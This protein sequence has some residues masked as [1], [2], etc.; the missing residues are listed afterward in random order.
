MYGAGEFSRCIFKHYNLSALNIIGIAD[1]RFEQKRP[2][3]FYG[4]TCLKPEDLKNIDCDVILVS[5]YD[6]IKFE[7]II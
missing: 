4:L 3:E 5:N 2:H 7:R 6:F 1:K